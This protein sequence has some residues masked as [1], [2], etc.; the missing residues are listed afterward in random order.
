MSFINAMDLMTVT[1]NGAPAYSTTSSTNVDL[2]FKAV[3]SANLSE[4]IDKVTSEFKNENDK[5]DFIVLAFQTRGTRGIGKGEKELFHQF[6]RKI[7]SE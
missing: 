2:F 5:V 4:L 1:E 3:R 6:L 7:H